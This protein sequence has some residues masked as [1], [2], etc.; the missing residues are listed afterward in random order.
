MFGSHGTNSTTSVATPI[1][2]GLDF[3][4]ATQTIRFNFGGSY[5]LFEIPCMPGRDWL[6][7]CTVKLR[8][9]GSPGSG[10]SAIE[11][12]LRAAQVDYEF[13]RASTWEPDSH[14]KELL[15]VNS[16]GQIPTL[17]LLDSTVLTESV[18][19]LINLAMQYP[20]AKLIPVE[21][22]AKALAIRGLVFIAA[23]CY[24]AVSVSD[25]PE[26]WTTAQAETARRQVRA[27]ARRQLHR[28]WEI[29]ADMVSSGTAICEAEPG[30]LE[31]LMVVVS[32]WS[33]S[34]KHLA[35]TRPNYFSLL[36]RLE[37]NPRISIVLREQS[38]A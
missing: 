33:G 22:S 23:N 35:D 32:R 15:E 10:S 3:V 36:K 29:L 8:L 5:E 26:R 18:A 4:V 24:S 28:N 13:V 34:R 20:D 7:G 31:F 11:M 2:I 30:A 37:Q 1:F 16:L 25:Y 19:I 38:A 14:I 9:F 6:Q 12:A 21:P 27:A 17:V